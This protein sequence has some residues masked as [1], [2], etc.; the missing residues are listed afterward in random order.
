MIK[1]VIKLPDSLLFEIS[2]PIEQ[3]EFGTKELQNLIDDLIDTKEHLHGVGIAAVQ[4][5]ILKRVAVI[6]FKVD[7][8]RYKNIPNQDDFVMIN[9]EITPIINDVLDMDEG[10]LSDPGVRKTTVRHTDISYKYYN[11]YGKL[12]TGQTGGFLAR[13]F[14]HEVDHMNGILFHNRS[15][16]L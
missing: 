4:I 8:P 2:E 16:K 5:G 1:D 13:V 7:N 15:I 10:C 11:Q 14:Q 12:V 9:P 6:G 3:Q